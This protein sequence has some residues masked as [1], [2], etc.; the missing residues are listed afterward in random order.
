MGY[1]LGNII[2]VEADVLFQ[3]EYG[4]VPPSGT[5]SHSSR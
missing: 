4:V 5:P 3:P 1:L 2:G